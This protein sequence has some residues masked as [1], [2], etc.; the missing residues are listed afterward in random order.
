M[1]VLFITA[2]PPDQM[3]GGGGTAARSILRLFRDPPLNA[4]VELCCLRDRPPRVPH[5]LRQLFALLRGII[6]GHASKVLISFPNAEISRFIERL[7]LQNYDLIAINGSEFFWL[8]LYFPPK[9][10]VI[11]FA[12]NVEADLYASQTAILRKLPLIGRCFER[13]LAKLREVET[14]G[15]ARVRN[16]L[17]LS[18]D[19]AA[20]FERLAPGTRALIQPT[21]FDYQ[22]Y[23]RD[24]RVRDRPLK[25]GFL[26]KYDWWPNRA[27]VTWLLDEVMP[28]LSPRCAQLLLFGP[29]AER[30][31]GAAPNVII[32]GFVE[33]LNEVWD[34][35]DIIVCPAVVGFGINIKF[36][37]AIYNGC[38]VLATT[39]AGS[40]ID[41]E[42]D[43][44]VLLLDGADKWIEFIKS[45]AATEFANR[46]P[47]CANSMRFEQSAAATRFA[48]FVR[49]SEGLDG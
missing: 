10:I 25:L 2:A 3:V 5:R 15:A 12:H 39:L 27:A 40:G 31:K 17:C 22:R 33:S 41:L 6:T 7:L 42:P 19:D 32:K 23:Q 20:E 35:S 21:T 45:K 37:E 26:A 29:G 43:P 48:Q 18:A 24:T 34:Q 47:I 38:P 9:K 4:T 11:G 49:S 8:A 14:A 13:D 30:F 1:R 16:I 28:A 44:A 46:T 36:V